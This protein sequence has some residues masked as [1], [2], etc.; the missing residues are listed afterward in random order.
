PAR[1]QGLPSSAQV[2]PAFPAGCWQVLLVPSH[3]SK[4]Q[5]FP[6][7]VQAVPL[8]FLTSVAGQV[9]LEPVQVSAMSHSPAASRQV[10]ELLS[11]MQLDLQQG[12][13]PGVQSHVG[14]A[15]VNVV[16]AVRREEAPVAV[17]LNVTPMSKTSTMKSV[18][19]KSPFASATAVSWRGGSNSGSSYRTKSTVSPGSQ[20]EPVMT[21]VSPGA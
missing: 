4:V 10:F 6:S 17:S 8:A 9:A 19:V 14:G 21:T 15:S 7:E 20:P 18:L 13:E 1:V 16:S 2:A 12:P 11:N 3:W 5:G